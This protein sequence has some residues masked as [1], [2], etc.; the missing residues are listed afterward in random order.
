MRGRGRRR[1]A[2]KIIDEEFLAGAGGGSKAATLADAEAEA[3]SDEGDG[4][5]LNA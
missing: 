5:T 4:G 3:G 1:G 2:G